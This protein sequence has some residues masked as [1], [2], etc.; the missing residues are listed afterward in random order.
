[1]AK[2][3]SDVIERSGS[4]NPAKGAGSLAR[5]LRIISV[6]TETPQPLSLAEISQQAGIDTSTTHR[7]LQ[8]LISEGQAL[9]EPGGK[10]YLASPKSLLPLSPYHALNLLR[11]DSERVLMSLRDSLGETASMVIYC[12]GERLL[13]ELAPGRNPLTPYYGTW[14][15]SP[16]YASASGKALLMAMSKEDRQAA[17]GPGPYHAHTP[18]TITNPD[19]LERHLEGFADLGYVVASDDA[20][21]GFTAIAAPLRTNTDNTLGCF[22]LTGSTEDLTGERI[23]EAGVKLKNAADLFSHGTP[24]L[25]ALSNFLGLHA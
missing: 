4:S 17:L 1:M 10:R 8:V 20:F 11:R 19:E 12:Y 14:L 13:L 16:L 21:V 9:K 23:H 18:Q 25:W 2:T 3:Q 5:G 22:A 6:L 7:L 24:S 15:S